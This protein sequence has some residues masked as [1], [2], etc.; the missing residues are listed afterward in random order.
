[1]VN[2]LANYL[3][4]K[5]FNYLPNNNSQ[6]WLILFLTNLTKKYN[7]TLLALAVIIY[8]KFTKHDAILILMTIIISATLDTKQEIKIKNETDSIKAKFNKK[9]I[10]NRDEH[11]LKLDLNEIK[12]GDI[13]YLT[14]NELV[15]ADCIIIEQNNLVIDQSIFLN[16]DKLN[17]FKIEQKIYQGY[18]ILNGS[19]LCQVIAI[20][21][22]TLLNKSKESA[23]NG[24]ST[25]LQKDLKDLQK[26]IY[27]MIFFSCLAIFFIGWLNGKNIKELLL[28]T[29]VMFIS[30]LPKGLSAIISLIFSREADY[31]KNNQIF[32]Q[33]TFAASSFAKAE[34]IILD[35]T[36]NLILEDLQKILN[37]TIKIIFLQQ[38]KNLTLN[39]TPA[40]CSDEIINKLQTCSLFYFKND[41]FF[42]KYELI[43]KLQLL[44]Y[45]VLFYGKN[46]SAIPLIKRADLGVVQP[47]CDEL[48]QNS[49]DIIIEKNIL[50]KIL[51]SIKI[52]CQ[53]FF[54]FKNFLIYYFSENMTELFLA[55]F[56]VITNYPF[57][58]NASQL[59]AINII[60]DYFINGPMV[61]SA[62]KNKQ[63]HFNEK[64][65]NLNN[66]WYIFNNAFFVFL[67][68]LLIYFTNKHQNNDYA[69][70][71]A[72]NTFISFQIF[73]AINC[74]FQKKEFKFKTIK[75][76]YYFFAALILVIV[77]QTMITYNI[78]GNNYFETVPLKITD[79]IKSI[80]MGSLILI[81]KIIRNKN[82]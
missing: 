81:P 77:L 42:A 60:I 14:V 12:V 30:L 33:N 3:F 74:K 69:Q 2:I 9:Y 76:N 48:T 37:L 25:P 44:D 53:I 58:L 24:E 26:I 73:S 70:T 57:L 59:L 68:T 51:F 10:I 64:L 63:N 82:Y 31:L 39:Y 43:Q 75:T 47:D 32:V 56:S 36:K 40:K 34:I 5:N 71:M 7:L 80:L 78:L 21:K 28:L 22:N 41:N 16:Y 66:F 50:K 52:S 72:F 62:Q 20:G 27:Y 45:T 4:S 29:T 55:F 6:N 1:M 65:I 61:Y 46:I 11:K 19:C 15:P 18:L 35:E 8:F 49:A 17:N 79:F 67:G 38:P 23:I 54:E 13:V